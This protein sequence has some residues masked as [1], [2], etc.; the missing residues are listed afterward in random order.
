[1]FLCVCGA[2]IDLARAA[3]LETVNDYRCQNCVGLLAVV[4]IVAYGLACLGSLSQSMADD[5]SLSMALRLRGS[6]TSMDRAADRNRRVLSENQTSQPM[7]GEATA[8]ESN[9]DDD[10][11]AD[12]DMMMVNLAEARKLAAQTNARLRAED[13]AT[14]PNAVVAAPAPAAP[15]KVATQTPATIPTPAAPEAM[16]TLTVEEQRNRAMWANAMLKVAGDFAGG[17]DTLPP[18]QRRSASVRA[19]SLTTSAHSLLSGEPLPAGPFSALPRPA[20]HH[21]EN[22]PKTPSR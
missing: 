11:A 10:A 16:V 1:V 4:Q 20:R 3:A 13:N 9:P 12:L 17:L 22:G 18:S 15:A 2:D 19:A 14:R 8:A 5:I 6:A 21:P 7:H